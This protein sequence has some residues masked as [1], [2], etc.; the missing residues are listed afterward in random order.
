M[1]QFPLDYVTWLLN[2]MP[3]SRALEE[4]QPNERYSSVTCRHI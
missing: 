1:A 4:L 2:Q 3:I